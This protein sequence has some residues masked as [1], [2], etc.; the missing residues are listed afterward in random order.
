[1]AFPTIHKKPYTSRPSDDDSTEATPPPEYVENVLPDKRLHVLKLIS[2]GHSPPLNPAPH[3]KFDVRSLPN[4]P[5][6]IRDAHNGTS[7]RLQEWLLRD[8]DFVVQRDMIVA[9][10][11]I[12]TGEIW[13][14]GH[15]QTEI[16][17]EV[18]GRAGKQRSWLSQDE[19][20][21]VVREVIREEGGEAEGME[22]LTDESGPPADAEW[23]ELPSHF[24]QIEIRVG[25]SCAMGRHRSVAMVENIAREEWPG[26]EV[27]V[28]HRDIAK[29]SHNRKKSSGRKS[30][31]I[32]G[33]SSGHHE[34]YDSC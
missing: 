27:R 19:D 15:E 34:D 23:S 24:S 7:K 2:H 9:G 10:I 6:H 1:M 29:K 28:E 17:E 32:R 14:I 26:W 20:Q 5:K 18:P 16:V 3:L 22:D 8:S 11:R 30:R 25:I 4:L 13:G 33:G 31:G 21:D 12:V